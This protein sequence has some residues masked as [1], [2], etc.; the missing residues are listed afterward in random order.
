MLQVFVFLHVPGGIFI[1]GKPTRKF[2]VEKIG[3]MKVQFIDIP[4]NVRLSDNG[5]VLIVNIFLIEI[6]SFRRENRTKHFQI[7]KTLSHFNNFSRF[8]GGTA[9]VFKKIDYHIRAAI[10]ETLY[11]DY[12]SGQV[13]ARITRTNSETANQDGE[14]IDTGMGQAVYEVVK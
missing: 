4:R 9:K 1:Q 13:L 5:S 8:S 11:L 14:T 3:K 7:E 2:K 10:D 6:G 12:A